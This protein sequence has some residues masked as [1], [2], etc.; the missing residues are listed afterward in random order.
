MAKVTELVEVD[1]EIDVKDCLTP[2]PV[3]VPD[4]CSRVLISEYGPH[5]EF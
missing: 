3:D 2:K 5:S 1:V 4:P